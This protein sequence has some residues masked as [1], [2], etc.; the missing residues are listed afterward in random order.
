MVTWTTHPTLRLEKTKKGS[1][2]M[3]VTHV[4]HK[5]CFPVFLH[6][7]NNIHMSQINKQKGEIEIPHNPTHRCWIFKKIVYL[8]T[9]FFIYF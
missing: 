8:F 4:L 1:M 7:P 2:T 9:Y 5:T 3:K 6:Y